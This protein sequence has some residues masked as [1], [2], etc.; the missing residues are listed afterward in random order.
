MRID[1][2]TLFPDMIDLPLRSS[3]IGRARERGVIDLR[4]HNIRDYATD[5]HHVVDDIPFG[6]GSGMVMM[7]GPL[8][9]AIKAID[10][11]DRSKKILTDAS[12]QKFDQVMAKKLMTDTWLLIICGHYKGIDERLKQLFPMLEVSIGD[13]VLTGGEIPALVL[14]DAIGRLVPGVIKEISSA[15]ND[16]YFDGLLGY[17]EYTQPRIFQGLSV[18]EVIVSGDHE[19]IRRWRLARALQKTLARRPDLLNDRELD[20]EEKYLL[21]MEDEGAESN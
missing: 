14:I 12:G 21:S 5:K 17:P 19:K 11:D 16:S 13:Y 6:G 1:V 15:E 18:P 2:L 3:M 20:E 8:Y 10:P 9:N 7:A 4:V